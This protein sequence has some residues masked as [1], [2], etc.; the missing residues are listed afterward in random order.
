MTDHDRLS[1]HELTDRMVKVAHDLDR[2]H[3]YDLLT[4]AGFITTNALRCFPRDDR[5]P[6][7]AEWY[8]KVVNTLR[9]SLD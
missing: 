5:L 9:E 7:A 3:A 8:A 4:I 1:Q 6:V 2:M